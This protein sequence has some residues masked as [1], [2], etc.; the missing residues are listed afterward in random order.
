MEQF[1][2]LFLFLFCLRFLID[3]LLRFI[4]FHHLKKNTGRV[5]PVLTE[6]I[7]IEKLRQIDLYNAAKMRFGILQLFTSNILVIVFLFTAIFPAYTLW[8]GQI[9]LP[10]Y[11]QGFLFF[12]IIQGAV[13]LIELHFDYYF[14]FRIEARF[15][16]NQYTRIGWLTDCLKNFL[17]STVFMG[18]II[19]FILWLLGTSFHFD[20]LK[21]VYGWS[22]ATLLIV[23]FSYLIPVVVTP[24]FYRLQPV[25]N[26]SLRGKIEE[27]VAQ[28]GF[29][30]KRI[31]V[32]DESSKSRHVN[33]IFTG[34]GKN[35]TI[36]LFDTL[37]NDFSEMEILAIL[38][39]EI[40]HGKQKHLLKSIVFSIIGIFW[41]LLFAAYLLS[42]GVPFAAFGVHLMVA[43]FYITYL[44]FF[45]ILAFF[46]QP[47]LMR[48]MRKFEY[49][50]DAYSKQLL[51]QGESLISALKKIM[52]HELANINIHPW[53]EKMYYSHPSLEKRIHA[54][55][56]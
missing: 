47:V 36:I 5:P 43:K 2:D 23:I 40:G 49:E 21:I 26:D 51:R 52:V 46:A 38:A 10:Y 18:V 8:I 20:W 28:S 12:F 25:S 22:I 42:A 50:A 53:Y 31:L 4:N 45:E 3:L 34:M 32:A 17:V 6:L 35:K 7:D 29:R 13:W 1:K 48:L 37:F 30:I 16:F 9:S 54:L 11:L 44:F 55:N 56:E 39:H 41:F 19:I 33:A 15:G 27:L 14:H 24:I